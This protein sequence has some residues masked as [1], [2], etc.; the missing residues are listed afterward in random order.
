MSNGW[1]VIALIATAA[2]AY[3]RYRA[4]QAANDAIDRQA[5]GAYE[6]IDFVRE[7][8]G[9]EEVTDTEAIIALR[10][11]TDFDIDALNTRESGLLSAVKCNEEQHVRNTD[12]LQRQG[13]VLLAQ[14]QRKT[15]KAMGTARARAAGAGVVAGSGA[16]AEVV[17]DVAIT[18]NLDR[19]RLALQLEQAQLQLNDEIGT[20]RRDAAIAAENL[21]ADREVLDFNYNLAARQQELSTAMRDVEREAKIQALASGAAVALE[22]QTS[23]ALG[24]FSTALRGIANLRRGDT[25]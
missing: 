16:T 13:A 24:A 14:E 10:E 19:L 25:G 15:G 3:T 20:S 21:Q 22:G 5:L 12:I 23:P 1:G 17:K 9:I 7:I 8:A 6:Q 4:G 11:K 2:G 18:G